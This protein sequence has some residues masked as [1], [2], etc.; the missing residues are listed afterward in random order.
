[1]IKPLCFIW[2]LGKRL[3]RR[4]GFLVLL[5]LISLLTLAYT[6]GT[7]GDAG[8]VTVALARDDEADPLAK[9]TMEAL[10]ESSELI[11]F[12]LCDSRQEAADKVRYGKADCA[13]VFHAGMEENVKKF[14]RTRSAKDAFATVYQREEMP[15]LTLARERL[16]MSVY[17]A[18]VRQLYLARLPQESQA[19]SALSEQELLVFW[20]D[21]QIPGELFAYT[22]VGGYSQP[23]SHLSSPVRGLLAVTVLLGGLGSCMYHKRD[24]EA[25][26]FRYLPYRLAWLP[27]LA[28]GLWAC[29]ALSLAAA[30][31]MALAGLAM[32][33]Y[34]EL[35]CAL[36]LA[37]ACVC[38]S[39]ALSRLLKRLSALAG[40]LPVVI[41]GA[42]V[43]S[44]VFF[45]LESLKLISY[46]LPTS[47]YL[48]AIV[49]LS[50]LGW[51]A[52]YSA[53]CFA[54]ALLPKGRH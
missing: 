14:L 10:P 23:E 13:W 52:V 46:L 47:Y 33:W 39:M 30:A 4:P 26:T 18:M 17:E 15:L 31:A 9:A 27:E 6:A 19:L 36:A 38:F 40:A 45:Q 44:P 49:D 41:A 20:E 22:Q 1:M 8:I 43:A 24:E 37:L 34:K 12:V 51:L 35:L 3:L 50:R 11:R 42:L 5:A 2:L 21:T 53:V 29:L 48:W 28:G 25:G 32:A 7:Q 54:L 16:N